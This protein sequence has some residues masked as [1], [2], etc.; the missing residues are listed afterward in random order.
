VSVVL[1]V[2]AIVGGLALPG[3]VILVLVAFVTPPWDA[4]ERRGRVEDAR[5]ARHVERLARD[6]RGSRWR[7]SRE[8]SSRLLL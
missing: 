8:R 5:F 1:G 6:P 4:S 7:A 2:L 3:F